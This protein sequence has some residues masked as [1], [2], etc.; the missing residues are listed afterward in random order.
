MAADPVARANGG[1]DVSWPQPG[2][3]TCAYNATAPAPAAAGVVAGC[4]RGEPGA[5]RAYQVCATRGR[6]NLTLCDTYNVTDRRVTLT[7]AGAAVSVEG[8]SKGQ[9]YCFAV[10]AFNSVLSSLTSPPGCVVTVPTA[11]GPPPMPAAPAAG[12]DALRVTLFEP[13]AV[14][15]DLAAVAGFQARPR[16]PPRCAAAPPHSRSLNWPSPRLPSL[17]PSDTIIPVPPHSVSSYASH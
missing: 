4:E 16:R 17:V 6:D 1:V 9:R 14:G 3:D 8:L 10:V 15:A 13:S 12:V 5:L 11:P 7:T 2:T